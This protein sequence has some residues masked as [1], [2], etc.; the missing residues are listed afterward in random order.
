MTV[1]LQRK[2]GA[3]GN[4]PKQQEEDKKFANCHPARFVVN[5]AELTVTWIFM[6]RFT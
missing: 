3:R 5:V 1:Y 6:A 2:E 4:S